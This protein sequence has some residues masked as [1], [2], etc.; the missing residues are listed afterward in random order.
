MIFGMRPDYG[1]DILISF[2]DLSKH[3]KAYRQMCLLNGNI[4]SRSCFPADIFNVHSGLLERCAKLRMSM[5]GGS[6][7]A[8]S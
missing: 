3:S 5:G 8:Y 1:N 2:D 6:I 4:P 7:T